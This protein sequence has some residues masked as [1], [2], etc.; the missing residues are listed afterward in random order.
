MFPELKSAQGF[1]IGLSIDLSQNIPRCVIDNIF[2][3][4]I[5]R[6]WRQGWGG[7]NFD[8]IWHAVDKTQ[9]LMYKYTNLKHIHNKETVQP[10]SHGNADRE[11]IVARAEMP[12]QEFAKT[13]SA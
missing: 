8:S 7:S 1:E 12:F 4:S 3:I 6:E 11:L 2:S 13:V 5:A 9:A 10:N